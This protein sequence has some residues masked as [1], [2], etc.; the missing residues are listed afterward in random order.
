M[1][2]THIDPAL[3]LRSSLHWA[4]ISVSTVS[5]IFVPFFPSTKSI[6]LIRFPYAFTSY[7]WIP[8]EPIN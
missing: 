8:F 6:W 2:I 3:S 4:C 7:L 5:L 1:S